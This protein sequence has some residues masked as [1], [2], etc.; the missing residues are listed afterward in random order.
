[1]HAESYYSKMRKIEWWLWGCKTEEEYNKLIRALKNQDFKFSEQQLEERR[2]KREL[3]DFLSYDANF[4]TGTFTKSNV[5]LQRGEVK[6]TIRELSLILQI[7]RTTIIRYLDELK[8]LGLIS[9]RR[10]NNQTIITLNFYPHHIRKTQVPQS[11]DTPKAE[12][13]TPQTQNRGHLNSS[14]HGHERSNF[15]AQENQEVNGKGGV[16][17]ERAVDTSK[18]SSVDTQNAKSWTP[19]SENRGHMKNKN[20]I[21]EEKELLEEKESNIGESDI[22][23]RP[24]EKSDSDFGEEKREVDREE[25]E[26][27][28]D[29]LLQTVVEKVKAEFK[30]RYRIRFNRFPVIDR[31]STERVLETLKESASNREELSDIVNRLIQKIP[32]FFKKTDKWVMQHGYSWYAFSWR[33]ADLL[34]EPVRTQATNTPGVNF[35][36]S[37]VKIG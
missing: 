23:S 37:V 11:V 17:T 12:S 19:K 35:K 13:W 2:K 21:L 8:E 3:V 1:M 6:R 14:V 15:G 10:E 30:V 7:P 24:A 4:K 5:T 36:V 9:I 34:S 26:E 22:N 18:S 31:K 27:I 28:T 16:S 32:D 33:I 20:I 25:K 29:T